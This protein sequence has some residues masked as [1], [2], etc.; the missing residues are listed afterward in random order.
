MDEIQR[1]EDAGA[2]PARETAAVSA[3]VTEIMGPILQNLAEMMK[4]NT[5]ALAQI[6]AAQQVQADRLEALERQVRLQT[7]VTA[8]MAA[9]LNGAAVSRAAALLE[10]RGVTD[11]K[12]VKKLAVVIRRAVLKRYG[13]GVMREIP[14]HEYSVAMNLIEGW[15]DMMAVRDAA[16]EAKDGTGD[17]I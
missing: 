1:R 15:N 17:G 14:R 6:A 11:G 7:P 3:L 4:R 2:L 9:Y 5:E 16:R 10:K 13:I 12:A 8:K